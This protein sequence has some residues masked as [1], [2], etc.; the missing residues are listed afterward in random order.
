M[1]ER[2]HSRDRI[3]RRLSKDPSASEFHELPARFQREMLALKKTAL[4]DQ[5]TIQ[6]LKSKLKNQ[7]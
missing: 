1:L 5:D 3:T 6:S 7:T 4:N 2:N